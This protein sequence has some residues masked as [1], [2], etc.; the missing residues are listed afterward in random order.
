[1]VEAVAAGGYRETSVGQVVALAGVSRRSF[2]EH[3]ANKQECLLRTFDLIVESAVRRAE[4][5]YRAT[6]GPLQERLRAS[7]GALAEAM[8]AN[9]KAGMLVM[10]ETPT[11]GGAGLLRLRD[12]TERCERMLELSFSAQPGAGPLPRPVVRAIAGGLHAALSMGVRERHAIAAGELTEG[13]LGWTLGFQS[14]AAP[15]MAELVAARARTSLAA[16]PASAGR[17]PSGEPQ[18]GDPERE[19]IMEQALRAGAEGELRELTAAR[20]AE[21]AG[22]S[23]DAFFELFEDKDQCYLAA[24]EMLAGRLLAAVDDER[25]CSSEW[26]TAVRRAIGE[27]ML[28]LADRPHYAGTIVSQALCAGPE[29]MRRN[30]ELASAIATRLTHG[31]PGEPV[32]RLTVEGVGGAIW[33]TVRCQVA[34]GRVQMLPALS[35]YLSYVVLAPFIGADAAVEVVTEEL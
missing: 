3:F 1:M 35:D 15:R 27:L 21:L 34:S 10:L 32:G 9:R 22:V 14:R 5:A 7:L 26:P 17:R 6:D 19:R 30:A 29:A 8:T 12:A 20:I 4:A 16:G 13:M 31:A 25:L 24:L 33:H 23:I 28:L 11:A 2:Y 18:P